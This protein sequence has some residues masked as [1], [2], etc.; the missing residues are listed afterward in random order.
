M[1]VAQD[2]RLQE[3]THASA[4]PPSWMTLY[5]ITKLSDAQFARGIEQNIIRP[6][7]DR[8]DLDALRPKS[9]KRLASDEWDLVTSSIRD[10][11]NTTNRIAGE[12]GDPADLRDFVSTLVVVELKWASILLSRA[13]KPAPPKLRLAK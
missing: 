5:E 6:D 2:K 1:V 7:M 9:G 13:M 3:A 12:E 8:K 4:L 10:A 11:I